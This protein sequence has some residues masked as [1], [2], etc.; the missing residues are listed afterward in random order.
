MTLPPDLAAC[1]DT[2]HPSF[3]QGPESTTSP[4]RPSPASPGLPPPARSLGPHVSSRGRQPLPQRHRSRAGLQLS[5]AQ[6]CPAM[7]PAKPGPPTGPRL[8]PS[9][10]REMPNAWGWSWAGEM[11]KHDETYPP[12]SHVQAREGQGNR[13]QP[14]WIYKSYLTS[15]TGFS[16]ETDSSVDEERATGIFH[17]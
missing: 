12:G 16:N 7:G 3:C 8:S 17:G 9:P 13:E 11:M 6:P 10:H 14:A 5:T 4:Y 2:S 15:L 1:A